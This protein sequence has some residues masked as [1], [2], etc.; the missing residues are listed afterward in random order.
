[1]KHSG[2]VLKKYGNLKVIDCTECK[3]IHIIPLPSK[4]EISKLYKKKYYTK[5]KP[6]YIR[7][8]ERE[9]DY[10]NLVFDE[11]LDYLETKIK[12]KTRSV[13]DVGSG[14]GFFLK[15][16]KEKG[17]IVNGVEPN[18]FAAKY[19]EKIGIPVITDFFQNILLQNNLVQL[20]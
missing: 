18:Y 19:S 5:I 8:Y 13:L 16:A 12:R 20:Q 2:K 7:K 4:K 6:Q 1:M 14:S 11:K 3:F 15:R 10:W 17:W 9:I